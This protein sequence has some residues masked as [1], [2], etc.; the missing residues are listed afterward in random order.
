MAYNPGRS[1]RLGSMAAAAII[2]RDTG[3]LAIFNLATRDMNKLALQT[4]LLE[5]QALGVDNVLILRGA[6]PPPAEGGR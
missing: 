1:V 5:A 3:R 6:R 4:R 2:Q